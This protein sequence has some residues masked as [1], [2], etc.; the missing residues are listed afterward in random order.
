VG[1]VQPASIP[2]STASAWPVVNPLASL[3]SHSAASAISCGVPNRPNLLSRFA[4]SSRI[5]A[6]PLHRAAQHRG[7]DRARA[8]GVHAG[9][10]CGA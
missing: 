6:A 2:P 3:Q 1:A 9:C 5:A 8:D 10:R 4:T 7:V